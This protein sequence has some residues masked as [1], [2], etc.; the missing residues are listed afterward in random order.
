MEKTILW[1]V[2]KVAADSVIIISRSTIKGRCNEFKSVKMRMA[3]NKLTHKSNDPFNILKMCTK[4]RANV[5][6]VINLKKSNQYFSSLFRFVCVWKSE[7]KIK[8]ESN[9]NAKRTREDSQC[10]FMDLD[11]T[12]IGLLFVPNFA[13]SQKLFS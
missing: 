4:Y 12:V 8:S 7:I 5:D 2:E 9:G 1:W 3:I 10:L 11:K 6:Q 13:Q